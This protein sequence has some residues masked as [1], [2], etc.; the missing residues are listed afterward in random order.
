MSTPKDP[1]NNVVPLMQ[2]PVEDRSAIETASMWNDL[3]RS[4][5]R[6]R[7]IRTGIDEITPAVLQTIKDD[8]DDKKVSGLT[9]SRILSNLTNVAHKHDS[10]AFTKYKELIKAGAPVDPELGKKSP[11]GVVLTGKAKKELQKAAE[12]TLVEL[13]R[14]KQSKQEDKA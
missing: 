1:D 8:L 4:R 7:T 9:A 10:L 6:S 12:S 3:M 2:K 5:S 13:T 14:L 11:S